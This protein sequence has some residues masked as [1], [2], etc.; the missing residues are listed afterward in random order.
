MTPAPAT[1]VTPVKVLAVTIT[2][3][4]VPGS[5]IDK[6]ARSRHKASRVIVVQLS[7]AVR[8][9]AAESLGNYTLT[10]LP[11]GR[12]KAKPLALAEATYNAA[13]FTVT[14]VTRKK[15]ATSPPLQ[16]TIDAAGL[17]LS[18][19]DIVAVLGK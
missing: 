10:T 8:G 2:P 16:L 19:S 17:G 18:G 5:S 7:E 13:T 9:S 11:R 15:L 4:P 6:T 1:P 14:L 12:K 3:A